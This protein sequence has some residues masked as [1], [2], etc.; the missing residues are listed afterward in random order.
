MDQVRHRG[1]GD[2]GE[3]GTVLRWECHCREPPVLLATYE[4][5][6]Q[7]NIKVRDRYWHVLGQ[8]RTICPRCGAEHVLDARPSPEPS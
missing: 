8:V 7:I 2:R 6:G 4:R 5:D 3:R 1:S